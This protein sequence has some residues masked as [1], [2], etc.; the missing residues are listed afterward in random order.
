M[1]FS[2]DRQGFLPSNGLPR[3]L[4]GKRRWMFFLLAG[5]G[6]AGAAL[7]GIIAWMMTRLL[8]PAGQEEKTA[9][10][11]VLLLGVLGIGALRLVE[12]TLA[13]KLGQHYANEIRGG[14]LQA[15]LHGRQTSVGITIARITND[16][17]SVRN[18]ITM[19]L[20]PLAA[21]VPLL[22]GTAVALCLVSPPLAL[23][24]VVPL[25]LLT[26]VLAL[27]AK[28]AYVRAK[29]LRR[30]RGRL[31]AFV[32]DTVAAS[33]SIRAAGGEQ[34]EIRRLHRLGGGVGEA[35][36]SKAV[37]AGT[38]RGSAAVAASLTA[39]AVAA[40]GAWLGVETS[41]VAAALTVVG[42]ISTPVTDLGRVVEYR[43][44][45][46]AAERILGPALAVPPARPAPQ[47]AAG[48]AEATVCVDG[49]EL[50]DGY[51]S[52]ALLASPGQRIVIDSPSPE[53]TTAL[54]EAML[55]L[56]TQSR[57]PGDT[58]VC[59]LHLASLQGRKRRE[60]VGYAARG[61]RLERGSIARAVRYRRPDLPADA[62]APALAAVGLEPTLN[63]LGPNGEQTMIRHGG[64]PLTT[65]DVARLQ[66][67]RAMLG[68]PPLLLLNRVD[69][70][71]DPDGVR[72]LA[73]ALDAYGGVAI[74][75][76][77]DPGSL[78]PGA[79]VWAIEGPL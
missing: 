27:L 41:T 45:F 4:A 10:I 26:I 56:N 32:A 25:S 79:R 47:R 58:W 46:R 20:A 59:G 29:A 54:F 51:R 30:R 68:D 49:M 15:A 70:D 5:S 42:L 37:V 31:A 43:Q 76:S 22:V 57:A 55:G 6:A 65:T 7:A 33:P 50:G 71:L 78:A 12:R 21:G 44:S 17:S 13:E 66:I 60:L 2:A 64:S 11:A 23:A 19:G 61:A 72:M 63:R 9:A 77:D 24:V 3:L 28:P 1:K 74:L 8:G 67:A 38:I 14:L 52:P 69:S 39:V 48:I 16:L 35:A 18:W 34:R 62:A 73:R 36:V 53:K 40:S 75:A